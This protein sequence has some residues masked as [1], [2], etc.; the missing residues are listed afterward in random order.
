MKLC[1]AHY[2]FIFHSL[3]LHFTPKPLQFSPYSLR[4]CPLNST[5]ILSLLFWP[6]VQEVILIV[7]IKHI[8]PYN[9]VHT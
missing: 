3:L 6:K 2:Y 4:N 8:L 9:K 1:T 7:H 5:L